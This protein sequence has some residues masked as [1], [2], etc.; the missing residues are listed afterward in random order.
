MN[1][2]Q[3][4]LRVEVALLDGWA[5]EPGVDFIVEQAWLPMVALDGV[6]VVVQADQRI[7]LMERFVLEALLRLET[8]ELHELQ[9]IASIPPELGA[10]L[11]GSLRQKGLV[12]EAGTAFAPDTERCVAA[13][14]S[15][16]HPVERS[17][18]RDLLWFPESD[19]VVVLESATRLF[20][21]LRRLKPSRRW[22]VPPG[23]QGKT[24]AAL[25]AEPF[26]AKRF[27]GDGVAD[28]VTIQ[29]DTVVQ[30]EQC[31]A[32][33]C[34]AA[35]TLEGCAGSW[36]LDLCGIE[37]ATHAR[38]TAPETL[39]LPLPIP[40]LPRLISTWQR[41]LLDAK[42]QMD[43]ELQ[44]ELG[45]A[46]GLVG[47]SGFIASLSAPETTRLAQ[48]RL[49]SESFGLRVRIDDEFQCIV[50]LRCSPADD[51]ASRLFAVDRVVRDLLSGKRCDPECVGVSRQDLLN[52]LWQLRFFKPLYDLRETADF[53]P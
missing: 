36:R 11:I 42:P 14:E 25:L 12:R 31:P 38:D 20:R 21:G 4:T 23:W 24:R 22:P 51:A 44:R 39:S 6:K 49:V 9:E 40:P 3:R 13:L 18:Q 46:V 35:T 27:H 53:S 2:D 19:E 8:L 26:N 33:R 10:W 32:Y 16:Q 29:D 15:G 43:V 7:S 52:R 50:P 5:P 37:R 34:S 41:W 48:N 30:G 45:I 17:E 28:I 1:S 47:P